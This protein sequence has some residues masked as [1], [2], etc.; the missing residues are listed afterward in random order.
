MLC[1]LLCTQ[2][3][4]GEEGMEGD[5]GMKGDIGPKVCKF[6]NFHLECYD[7]KCLTCVCVCV[8][9]LQLG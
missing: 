9:V 2:G 6:K 1:L 3:P 8:C 5:P 4:E 7:T